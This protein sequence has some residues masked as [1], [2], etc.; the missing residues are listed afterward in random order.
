MI[1]VLRDLADRRVPLV[2][3]GDHAVPHGPTPAEL[4]SNSNAVHEEGREPSRLAATEL[5]GGIM[6][7]REREW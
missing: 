2:G 7:A 5:K 6:V 4:P 3:P 1:G